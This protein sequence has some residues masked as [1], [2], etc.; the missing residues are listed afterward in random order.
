MKKKASKLTL[1]RETLVDLEEDLQ[2]VAG[3]MTFGGCTFSGGL[4]TCATCGN[5]CQTNRC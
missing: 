2:R 5:T 4:Q 3:G 1:H